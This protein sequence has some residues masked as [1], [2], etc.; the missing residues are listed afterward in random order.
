[1]PKHPRKYAWPASKIDR[2]VMHELHLTSRAS[3]KK[4]T[5]LIAEAVHGA[6]NA[7]LDRQVSAPIGFTTAQQP[8]SAA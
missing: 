8:Q 7:R 1:M 6:M 3:G 4:I 5:E 2:D